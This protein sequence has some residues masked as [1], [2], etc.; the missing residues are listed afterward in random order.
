M[1]SYLSTK[2]QYHECMVVYAIYDR[3]FIHSPKRLEPGCHSF[4]V[5]HLDL[6]THLHWGCWTQKSRA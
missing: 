5:Q 3:K 1:V 6:A 4:H 2:V